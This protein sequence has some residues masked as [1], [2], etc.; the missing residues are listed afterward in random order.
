MKLFLL[1]QKPGPGMSKKIF[2]TVRLKTG[3]NLQYENL[4]L[5]TDYWNKVLNNFKNDKEVLGF[6][7]TIPYKVKIR[8]E[9]IGD[10]DVEKCGAVNCVKVNHNTGDFLG[11]NTDWKGIYNPLAEKKINSAIITGAGGA[12]RAACYAL[13]KLSVD[14]VFLFNRSIEKADVLKK[15]FP[16]IQTFTLATID[17]FLKVNQID[18]II[19]T[20]PLGMNPNPWTSIPVTVET[21]KNCKIV[22]DVVYKPLK[23]K[24]LVYA[25]KS[26]CKTINGLEML[27]DQHVENVKIW[28]LPE[29]EKVIEILNTFKKTLT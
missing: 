12:A 11:F 9:V 25:E 1:K 21:L 13:E 16:K 14:N 20:T 8:D 22:F 17:D 19:N 29:E 10:E 3:I 24:L 15:L 26:G 7:I 4:V 18:L 2:D 28:G 6:N 27:V 5:P 23:T